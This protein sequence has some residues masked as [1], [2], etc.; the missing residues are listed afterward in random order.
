MDLG[1]AIA[2]LHRVDPTTAIHPVLI[3]MAPPRPSSDS[4]PED[5]DKF[6]LS[7]DNRA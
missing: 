7:P 2:I 6:A 3:L 5:A 1:R 4:N